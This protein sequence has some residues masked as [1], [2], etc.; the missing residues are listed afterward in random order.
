MTSRSSLSGFFVAVFKTV[1]GASSF[2]FCAVVLK[3]GY[4]G[5]EAPS[6]AEIDASHEDIPEWGFALT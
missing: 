1:L 2:G 6:I 5:W 4:G 3:P